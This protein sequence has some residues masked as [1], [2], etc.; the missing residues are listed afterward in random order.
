MDKGD[1]VVV[2]MSF[3]HVFPWQTSPRWRAIYRSGPR[4]PGDVFTLEVDVGVER[5]DGRE[6]KLN[7]NSDSFIG[8]YE[9]DRPAG[10]G[11]E[12]ERD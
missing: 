1:Q 9:A 2:A 11:G 4:G 8:I 7:G 12:G 6:V 5:Y 10:E 3:N